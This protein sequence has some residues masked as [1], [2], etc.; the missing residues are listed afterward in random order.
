MILKPDADCR[1][2]I[3]SWIKKYKHYKSIKYFFNLN[4]NGLHTETEWYKIIYY[5][6]KLP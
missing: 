1:N 3:I 5:S 2:Y 6:R 4:I